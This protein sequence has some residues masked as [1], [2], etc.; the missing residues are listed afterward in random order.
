MTKTD[1]QNVEAI[2]FSYEKKT[3]KQEDIVLT[4]N[5]T[6]FTIGIINKMRD[7]SGSW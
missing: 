2:R 1:I 4:R 7:L 6:L 3:S 5:L